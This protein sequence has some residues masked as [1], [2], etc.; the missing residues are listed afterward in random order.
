MHETQAS[1]CAMA[2]DALD[3]LRPITLEALEERA[4]LLRRVDTKYLVAQ[5]DLTVLIEELARD[6][7]VLEIDGQR[8]FSYRSVYFDTPDMR[9]FHDHVNGVRPRFKLRTRCYLDADTC[10]FEVKLKREDDETSKRQMPYPPAQA[11]QLTPEAI[12]F[13]AENLAEAGIAPAGELRPQLSTEFDRVTL[14]ARDGS[15]RITSD[16]S[17]RLLRLP[18]GA[19]R[20]MDASLA[21]VETKS[22]DGGGRADE[23]LRGA[24]FA[25]VSISKYRTGVD[26]LIER[27]G[28]AESEAV[29]RAFGEA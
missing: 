27:D 1:C 18:G 17:L 19:A 2:M 24:G 22:E 5:A 4:A 26:L 16:T 20:T 21:L 28:A 14:V 10:Q 23:L 29:R 11:E 8:R 7:D 12:E 13:V 25:P 15:S 9:A 6:H 3:S